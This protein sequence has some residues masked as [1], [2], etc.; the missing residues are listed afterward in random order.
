MSPNKSNKCTVHTPVR[1]QSKILLKNRQGL[2]TVVWIAICRQSG[3]Q[4]QSRTL[5]Q[6][7]FDLR[8]SIVLVF[9]IAPHPVWCTKLFQKCIQWSGSLIQVYIAGNSCIFGWLKEINFRR[10]M[11]K[12]HQNL[13]FNTDYR[14]MQVKS[15]AECSKHSAILST[16][17]NLPFS[18]KTL[19]FVYF[20]WSLKTGFTVP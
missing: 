13:V 6:T 7:D 18:V 17:I 20:K 3:D 16:F 2:E 15:I 19:S 5:F 4:W 9:S 8:L 1:R 12:E 11:A 10:N 14:L